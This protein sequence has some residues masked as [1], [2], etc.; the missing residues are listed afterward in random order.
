MESMNTA[1]MIPGLTLLL[2][3]WLPL[4]YLAQGEA[5]S[6]PAGNVLDAKGRSIG[7]GPMVLVRGGTVQMGIDARE[8]QSFENIFD[9]HVPQVFQD[10]VPKHWVTL[11]DFYIDK[12]LVT[13]AQFKAFTDANPGWQPDRIARELDDGNYLKHWKEP[14]ALAAN[15]DHPVVNVNWYSALAF[16]RWA[17]KRLPS[18]A[19]WEYA[20]RGGLNTLFPW[21]DQ[22]A[23]G[24]R[25]NYSGSRLGI[26]SPVGTYPANRYGLFD[27]AGNVWQFMADEWK[28]Y[29]ATPQKNPVAGEGLS[30]NGTAFLQVKTRRVIRGG[31]FDG[32]PVNL[33]V[34]YRDS[35]PASGSREFV[36]F[37]CAK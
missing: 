6:V 27:M 35:H 13:N 4:G 23:D 17:G 12:Y 5:G 32:A 37:R 24:T 22:P 14:T 31:S 33:W 28:P 16:C 8:I 2:I 30:L 34:E 20:A 21:G 15:A 9:V 1:F 19:E 26:T 10:E 3:T 29:P 18:E 7:V 36:G 25:A 11:G